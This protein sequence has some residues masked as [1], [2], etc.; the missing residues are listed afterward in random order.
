MSSG[1]SGLLLR[2]PNTR[3]SRPLPG[4]MH[5]T[6]RIP[7]QVYLSPLQVAL[8]EQGVGPVAGFRD[9]QEV[10]TLVILENAGLRNQEGVPFGEVAVW[11]PHAR[12]GRGRGGLSLAANDTL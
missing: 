2:A 4:Q 7:S 11:A 1:A 10:P 12:R 9:D 8:L 6:V 5:R 3:L